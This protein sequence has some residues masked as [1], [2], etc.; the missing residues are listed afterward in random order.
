D[1]Y[2]KLRDAVPDGPKKEARL[3]ALDRAMRRDT[4][5]IE[6]VRDRL[7]GTYAIP[8]DAEG[9]AHRATVLAKQWNLMRLGGG[10]LTASLSDVG[11]I[12]LTHGIQR[13]FGREFQNL[14]RNT[15]GIKINRE[16]LRKAGLL[17]DRVLHSR[18]LSIADI[19]DEGLGRTMLERASH[20]GAEKANLL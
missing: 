15:E 3:L 8:Q 13:M 18:A 14:I 12:S 11:G 4:N 19:G 6:G 1:D 16:E 9:L 20:W 7:R 5:M 2:T 10:F 17:L